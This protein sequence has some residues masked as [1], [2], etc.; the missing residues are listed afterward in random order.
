MKK[1]LLFYRHVTKNTGLMQIAWAFLVFVMAAPNVSAQSGTPGFRVYGTIYEKG[2]TGE[3]PL[4]YAAISLT[5]YAISATS[6]KDG[7]FELRNVPAGRAT[8]TV[9][10]LGKVTIDTMINVTSDLRLTLIMKEDNFRLEEVNVTAQTNKAGQATSS[11]IS[12]QAMDHLQATSLKDVLSLLPGHLADNQNLSIAGKINLRG[13]PDVVRTGGYQSTGK[14][15]DMNAMGVAIIQDGAPISNN[16]NLQNN[17]GTATPGT[18]LGSPGGS[19]SPGSGIDA[20]S[21]STDNIESIEVIQGIPSVEYGDVTSGLIII[22]SKAG[23]EPLRINARTNPNV[24]QLSASAGYALG[25]N[26]GALNFGLDYARSYSSLVSQYAFYDRTT[27]K[28]LYSNTFFGGT[29][30][31][32]T[33]LNFLY[34]SDTRKQNPDDIKEK[35]KSGGY[36]KAITLTTNGSWQANIGWLK[37]INYALSGSFTAR[38]S[39]SQSLNNTLNFT[40]SGTTTDGAVLGMKGSEGSKPVIL[41]DNNGNP[42]TALDPANYPFYVSKEY[43]SRYDI[44][45]RDVSFFGKISGTLFKKWGNVNNRILLGADVRS[46]GNEGKGKYFNYNTPIPQNQTGYPYAGYRSRPFKDVPY[47]NQLGLYAEDNFN[48]TFAGGRRF[49]LQA[50]VRYDKISAANSL[51]APRVNASIDILPGILSLKGG[52]G[53][54]GKMPTLLY[55][56][57]ENAYFEFVNLSTVLQQPTDPTK[58]YVITTTRVFDARNY[59]LEIAENAKSEIGFNFRYKQYQLTVTG[60]R[61]RMNNGFTMNPTFGSFQHVVHNLFNYDPVTDQ[62]SAGADQN[63]LVRYLTPTNNVVLN[64]DG[65][66]FTLDLGRFKAIRTAFSV[67]GAWMR[68]ETYDK[69]YTFYSK[70]NGMNDANQ[71]IGVYEQAKQKDYYERLITTFRATHNIPELGFVITLTAQVTWKD[72]NWNTFGNDSIPVK[73]I[74]K[75]DGKVYD[76]PYAT[77]QEATAA[78]FG[79]MLYDNYA[80]RT[81]SLT[82]YDMYPPLVCFNLNVTKEIADFFR[83]SFFANNMFRSYPTYKSRRGTEVIKRNPNLFFG[84]ELS[85]TIK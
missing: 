47:I 40:Y 31:S 77:R 44:E 63:V 15:V 10:M 24:Y 75:Q 9:R 53:V 48:W 41:Y 71:S 55:L 43:L 16:A 74:S 57:P 72:A 23:R 32:N 12:R 11:L 33:S 52:Y 70:N 17:S 3:A 58:Q 22:N 42:I 73:Y 82:F 56:Y 81:P 60:F 61:E 76:F 18:S 35:R 8:L 30:K 59:D 2:K 62:I 68:T 4:P 29:W 67:N 80:G 25:E 7:A 49:V 1:T 13:I 21:I 66:E 5:D 54:T 78:G 83:V 51:V 14:G 27:A 20:R 28:L 45:G 34:G 79:N 38:D 64:T 37:T 85:L 26:R 19:T 39:Y 65:V 69:G 36:D 46:D 84:L 50:G 6:G